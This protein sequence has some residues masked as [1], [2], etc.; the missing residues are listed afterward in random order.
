M[1]HAYSN[2]NSIGIANG[3]AHVGPYGNAD[4]H[5]DRASYATPKPSA[6]LIVLHVGTNSGCHLLRGVQ[7]RDLSNSSRSVRGDGWGKLFH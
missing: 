1:A 5:A 7:R 2:V 3:A 6:H 4:G